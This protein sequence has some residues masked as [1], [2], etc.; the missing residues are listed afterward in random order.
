MLQR[1]RKNRAKII[2]A[3]AC[4]FVFTA[5]L[6]MSA[7][8]GN[9]NRVRDSVLRL[10]IIANSDAEDDQALKLKVRDALL[11]LSADYFKNC[12]TRD[13]SEI[14]AKAHLEDLKAEAQ[15]VI[16]ENGYDYNVS[17]SVGEAFFGTRRYDKFTLPAGNYDALRVV[18]GEGRGHNWWCVMFP[19]VCLPAATG[20]QI[21]DALSDRDT[22]VVENEPKYKA[23][24]K[25]VELYEK[26][27]KYLLG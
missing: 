1:I 11:T 25:C 21:G 27:K 10:H 26:A 22:E 8:G 17:V 6:G 16:N 18:I 20:A 19:P 4:A 14:A 24:F 15:R 7:F 23:E 12:K 3:L 13:D 2:A 5:L 9:C